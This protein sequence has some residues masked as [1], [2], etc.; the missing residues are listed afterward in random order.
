[1]KSKYDE[2]GKQLIKLQTKAAKISKNSKFPKD[3]IRH[4]A[5]TH[6]LGVV[7]P[8][9]IIFN[10]LNSDKKN[11]IP[12]DLYLPIFGLKKENTLTNFTTLEVY[13]GISFIV[14]FH[15][16]L[17]IFLKNILAELRPSVPLKFYQIAHQLLENISIPDKNKKYAMMMALTHMRNGY[18]ANGNHLNKSTKLFLIKG[19]EFEFVKGQK[20]KCNTQMHALVLTDELVTIMEEIVNS[21][22]VQKITKKIPDH[23]LPSDEE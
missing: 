20:F 10:I 21:P 22:E 5:F 4:K 17:E 15:F 11:K 16:G 18:H 23:Y 14:Q 12:T 8:T 13:C 7:Q 9:L 1:M 19:M 2:T 3:D 6:I